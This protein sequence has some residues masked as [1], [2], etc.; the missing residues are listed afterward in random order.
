MGGRHRRAAARHEA[1]EQR[2]QATGLHQPRG[3]ALAVGRDLAN[4]GGGVLADGLI[5]V[6]DERDERRVHLR[7]EPL[8][9]LAAP[10]AHLRERAER[11]RTHGR[12]AAREK[13]AEGGERTRA[14]NGGGEFRVVLGHV[15]EDRRANPQHRQLHFA[16]A[17]RRHAQRARVDDGGGARGA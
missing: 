3:L 5:P 8:T 14:D 16:K 11:V 17:E 13:A 9:R 4:A 15:G 1:A 10:L 12:V 2:G 6:A 7:T